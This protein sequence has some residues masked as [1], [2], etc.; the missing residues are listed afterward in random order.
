M[1]R[2]PPHT[3]LTRRAQYAADALPFDP[4]ERYFSSGIGWCPIHGHE[5]LVISA[6]LE[7]GSEIG[8]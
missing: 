8:S 2:Y 1:N 7:Y 4:K 6:V 3:E 5:V